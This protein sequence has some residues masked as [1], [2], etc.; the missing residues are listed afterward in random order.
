M[1]SIQA[2]SI[3]QHRK[4]EFEGREGAASWKTILVAFLANES[5]LP[6]R[7]VQF[8]HQQPSSWHKYGDPEETV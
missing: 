3:D 7:F 8:F 4:W 6:V 1:Y 2:W 5:F